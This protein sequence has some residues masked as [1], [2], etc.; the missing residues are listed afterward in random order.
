MVYSITGF[1]KN[2]G[3]LIRD[4]RLPPRAGITARLRKAIFLGNP[5]VGTNLEFAVKVKYSEE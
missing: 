4:R 1:S 3:V 5:I 2:A